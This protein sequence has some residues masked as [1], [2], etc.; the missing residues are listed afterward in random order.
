MDELTNKKSLEKRIVIQSYLMTT[1]R[2]QFSTYEKKL[3]LRLIQLIQPLLDGQQ[4]KGKVVVDRDLFD[5]SYMFHLPVSLLATDTHPERF[6]E[7]IRQLNKKSFE[8]VNENGDWKIIRL[9]ETPKITKGGYVMF[10]LSTELVEVFLDFSKGYSK[11]NTHIS[12]NLKSVYSMRFY[13]LISNQRR[14]LTFKVETLREMFKLG[15]KYKLI[16]SFIQRII[17]P[18]KKELDEMSNWTFTYKPIKRGR[19]FEYIQFTPI[20][21]RDKEDLNEERKDLTKRLGLSN[22]FDREWRKLFK[23]TYGF[24]DRQIKN[25]LSTF[26]T[27]IRLPHIDPKERLEYF[28]TYGQG[29]SNPK[30]YLINSMKQEIDS[31]KQTLGDGSLFGY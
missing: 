15:D 4:L 25:N 28:W 6:K 19:K 5:E 26:Q 8:H 1:S 17:E 12:L 21:Q 9:I 20:H 3:L 29:T 7:A 14:P 11:F 2:F 27:F 18:S 16:G 31:F 10:R 13:E 22:F 24:T 30:G 23:E